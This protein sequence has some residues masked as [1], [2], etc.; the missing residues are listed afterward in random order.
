MFLKPKYRWKLLPARPK[1]HVATRRRITY[2]V[3]SGFSHRVMQWTVHWTFFFISPL[4]ACSDLKVAGIRWSYNGRLLTSTTF[5]HFFL[6]S[7]WYQL[8]SNL[9]ANSPLSVLLSLFRPL[10]SPVSS[11]CFSS[12]DHLRNFDHTPR[13]QIQNVP[14]QLNPLH[15]S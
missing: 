15:S 3:G 4:C 2:N 13:T 7:Q 1:E 10:H 14:L 6:V 12:L 9:V 8:H 5:N 11:F